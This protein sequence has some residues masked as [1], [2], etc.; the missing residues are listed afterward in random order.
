MIY[1]IAADC[2]TSGF[3]WAITWFATFASVAFSGCGPSAPALA[4][5]AVPG[6]SCAFAAPPNPLHRMSNS[7]S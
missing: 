7:R 2:K 1:V 3:W 6:A 5:T 4:L